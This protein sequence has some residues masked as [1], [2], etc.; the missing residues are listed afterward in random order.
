MMLKGLSF[1]FVII[2]V[3]L[4]VVAYTFGTVVPPGQIGVRQITFGPYQGFSKEGLP[5]GYHWSIPVYSIVHLVPQVIQ[6]LH[7]DK[8]DSDGSLE[9][10]GRWGPIEVQ[11]TDGSSVEVDLSILSRFYSVPGEKNGG[12][13]DLIQKL[14]TSSAEWVKRLHTASV[15]ELRRSLGRLSTSEFY[16]PYKREKAIADAQVALDSRMAEFGIKIEAILLRRYVYT[17][18]RIDS[19]I[20]QKNLQDQE[21]RLNTAA[22]FL[23]EARAALEKISAEWDAKIKTLR[24]EG[25]NRERVIRSE[26]DLYE[27]EKKAEGDFLVAKAKAE[28]DRLKAN[29]LATSVGA[30]IFVGKQLAPLVSSLKGGVLSEIDPYNLEEWIRK[31]GLVSRTRNE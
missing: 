30:K 27:T 31:M 8:S 13:S 16:D 21:E 26:A 5:P 7:L 20:F 10:V 3:A 9:T 19:A 12:P 1:F 17:E 14:G 11:T 29:A 23:A 6:S 28:V 15:N 24:V 25:E 18:E 2:I 22:S 4:L